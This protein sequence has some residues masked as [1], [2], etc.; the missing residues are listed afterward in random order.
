[1]LVN[2]LY[3]AKTDTTALV[4]MR[5]NVQ[6]MFECVG[7]WMIN[8]NEAANKSQGSG[9][10]RQVAG[11]TSETRQA[12]DAGA[13]VQRR[14]STR[15]NERA[16]RTD[17][18]ALHGAS[19]Y[20]RAAEY[21]SSWYYMQG[22]M[23]D[24]QSGSSRAAH[25]RRR[26]RFALNTFLSRAA[27]LY[28]D[29]LASLKPVASAFYDSRSS[30]SGCLE[31]TRTDVLEKMLS[32]AN[33]LSPSMSIFWLAG[34][35]GTGK[36]TIAKTFCERV[37]GPQTLLATFFAS[38]NSAERRDPFNI[39]HTFAHELAVA[40][41][42][43]RPQI[44]S[45]IRSPPDIHERP[46]KEQIE[47]LLA[48]PFARQ[49]D[50]RTIILVIDALDECD[51]I[52]RAEGGALIQLLA[53]AFSNQ[54]VR[55]LVTS[56]QET[57]LVDMFKSLT[58]IPLR[59][60]EIETTSVNM[61]VR[62]ILESGFAD[63]RRE[64]GLTATLWPSQDEMDALVGLTGSFLIFAAT[65]LR[66]IGDDR[67]DP[68]E[69]LRGVLAQGTTPEGETPYAQI[70]ALYR[71]ILRAATRDSSSRVDT[72]DAAARDNADRV[73]LRLC[74]RIGVLLRTIIL[75]E[76]PLSV[77]A[78]AQLMGA[79]AKEVEK[80]VGALAAI[81]LVA[82]DA[83]DSSTGLVQ[84]FHPSLRDFLRDPQRCRD[85]HL[86]VVSPQHDHLVA[87]RCLLIMNQHLTRN[88]CRIED[89]TVPN[90]KILDFTARILKFVPAALQYACVAWLVHI[91]A[92]DSPSS[93]LRTALR[94][95]SN[96]HLLHWV[97]LMS[98]LGHLSAAA[99]RLPAVCAWSRVIGL[100]LRPLGDYTEWE[101]VLNLLEDAHRMLRLYYTPI[102]S[103]A[104]HIYHSALA[105]M[106]DCAL[107]VLGAAD[108]DCAP[109]L[110]SSRN[111]GWGSTLQ[112]MNGHVNWVTSVAFSPD[113]LRVVSGSKDSTVR[114]WNTLNGR[115]L[116]TCEGPRSKICSVAFSPDGSKVVSGSD[117]S[118]IT[119]DARTGVQLAVL[120]WHHDH[121]V[122]S[123]AFCRNVTRIAICS[124][125][126]HL[127]TLFDATTGALLAVFKGHTGHVTSV[128]FS[129]DGSRLASGSNDCTGRIWDTCHTDSQ[130]IVLVGHNKEVNSVAFSNDGD[131]VVSASDDQTTRLWDAKTGHQLLVLKGHG[132]SVRSASFTPDGSHVLSGSHDT[133]IRL[134]DARSGEQAAV[135]D[136]H[137]L[138]VQCV[139]S[140]PD[141]L[142]MV[143]GSCD[144]MV[145]VW[146]LRSC[147]TR[148]PVGPEDHTD[149]G[150][151]RFLS[152]SQNGA[153]IVSV[154]LGDHA[155]RLWD[156]DTGSLLAVFKGHKDVVKCV[157]FSHNGK[158][159]V[160]GSLDRTVRVWNTGAHAGDA[161]AIFLQ[162][163]RVGLVEASP[164]GALVAV[165]SKPRSTM[166]G[167]VT[168]WDVE[169]K[170]RLT[171]LKGFLEDM[172][173]IGF[174]SSGAWMAASDL[175]IIHLW[176]ARTWQKLDEIRLELNCF[177]DPR[178]RS[179]R[180]TDGDIL[181]VRSHRGD[182]L[183]TWELRQG[184]PCTHRDET[185][186]QSESCPFAA[187]G[188]LAV[189]S[190]A[191][192]L[193]CEIPFL[194][195]DL[196]GNGWVSWAGRHGEPRL[197][198][199]WLPVDRRG[200][201][202]WRGN[203][204]IVFGRQGITTVLDFT[205]TMSALKAIRAVSSDSR[206]YG[207]GCQ[208]C[209]RRS[210]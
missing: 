115:L 8:W 155:L 190:V 171:V 81:L 6:E 71:V 50:G 19:L 51:K 65:A 64:H 13:Q 196:T 170:R 145:I 55:L 28:T 144:N 31:N 130:S 122:A 23:R 99:E 52:G 153:R 189:R 5:P 93:S 135:F 7:Q 75:L 17:S 124:Q 168:I 11:A 63:I 164:D 116:V 140:S 82:N 108:F 14:G 192:G 134:W 183:G 84:V 62:R 186:S 151:V 79:P 132:D 72:Q 147:M 159:I 176:D 143:S 66:Y 194:S 139:A 74:K 208:W 121:L 156:A 209:A 136:G 33:D 111:S 4:R 200:P 85:N 181:E 187:A 204:V 3:E 87:E 203:K 53:E 89:F 165:Y 97:E 202:A 174:S 26:T 67:F 27:H 105:T 22:R 163:R 80:D 166:A 117:D 167:T 70:D 29:A 162:A 49:L 40:H 112:V 106:P 182:V 195:E 37:A 188:Q 109:R 177:C 48:N 10:H 141:G 57:S 18:Q 120:K 9:R 95:F 45:A 88:I 101:T 152:F 128:A 86:V 90:S 46:M 58:H 21:Y 126:N 180:F 113:G 77:P 92:G 69:Q 35:A 118:T 102:E 32:W 184:T 127:V 42:F 161:E 30:P 12:P 54:P 34:L 96:T 61:D 110:S 175:P 107:S 191:A 149:L 68:V 207:V 73:N 150:E 158:R 123:V 16:A 104:L 172:D 129:F 20:S 103:Y 83:G 41:P 205:D 38:R 179:V 157:S 43:I 44:I 76:E 160:S 185:P 56:R 198:L 24:P 173:F 142:H 210:R 119:W 98:L 60:H 148:H 146:D 193:S 1:V 114:I 137:T 36:T 206:V 199:C 91:T 197:P 2:A 154:H 78:L 94:D 169:T 125:V 138:Q 59:L 133:T 131:R 15:A 201:S 47:R 25:H 39:I 100:R 178:L